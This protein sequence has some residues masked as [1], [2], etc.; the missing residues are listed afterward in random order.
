LEKNFLK[1]LFSNLEIWKIVLMIVIAVIVILSGY[2]VTTQ[3]GSIYKNDSEKKLIQYLV[4]IK[5]QSNY[6]VNMKDKVL[7]DLGELYEEKLII[8]CKE[9]NISISNERIVADVKYYRLIVAIM[10]D[11]CEQFTLQRYIF[12]NDLYRYT[13]ANDWKEFKESVKTLF[14]TQG[15]KVLMDNYDNSKVLMPANIWM[16]Y[17]GRELV[18]CISDTT[19]VMLEGL[20]TESIIFSRLR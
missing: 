8:Y 10:N 5:T 15:R 4:K 11:T 20:K 14:I 17:A 9:N 12:D 19:D 6:A 7:K 1:T 16:K 3:F 2:T 13:N 18:A